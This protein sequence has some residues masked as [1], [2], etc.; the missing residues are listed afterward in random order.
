MSMGK[1]FQIISIAMK[2]LLHLKTTLSRGCLST[3]IS[4]KHLNVTPQINFFIINKFCKY[5]Q[6]S[7][8]HLNFSEQENDVK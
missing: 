7:V 4:T 2:N 5:V 6:E 1:L 8:F 3:R